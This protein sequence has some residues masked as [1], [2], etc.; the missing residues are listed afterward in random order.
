MFRNYL[1]AALRNLERNSLY[2]GVTIFGLAIGF[3]AALLIALFVRGELTYDRFIPGHD[4]VYVYSER[5]EYPG[6]R[7]VLT[8]VSSTRVG[9]ALKAEIP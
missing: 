5:I 7:P 1:S 9:P 2:A 4:Q 6:E 3:A 8:D